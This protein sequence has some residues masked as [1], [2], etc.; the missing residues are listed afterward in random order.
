M[1]TPWPKPSP[2]TTSTGTAPCAGLPITRDAA[3]TVSAAIIVRTTRIDPSGAS[4]SA[5]RCPTVDGV[6][7]H[8]GTEIPGAG[9]RTEVV[10]DGAARV[11]HIVSGEVETPVEYVQERDEWVLLLE[12]DA[13]L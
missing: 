3:T 8:L 12:G 10:V 5:R 9:E 7:G 13:E 2:V 4:T 1:P 6:H 11:E